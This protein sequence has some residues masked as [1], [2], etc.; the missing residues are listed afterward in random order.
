MNYCLAQCVSGVRVL[1][2]TLALGLSVVVPAQ[3]QTAPYL[4][5]NGWTV[6]TPSSGTRTIYI[7][8]SSGND[9]N[10]GLSQSTPVKTIAKGVSLLRDGYPDWLL[11]KKGDAWTNEVLGN[12]IAVSGRSAAE[13]MLISSYGSGAR[14]L[15]K[16]DAS[17][18]GYNAALFSM[19]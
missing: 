9:S 18:P 19:R 2:T 4:D 1:L 15:L 7:S 6:F 5:P 14:P 3:A 12:P 10:S 16:T 17:A 13:P 11:L 8:N